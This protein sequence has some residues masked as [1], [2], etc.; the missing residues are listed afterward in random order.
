MG[1]GGQRQVQAFGS[2]QALRF[3]QAQLF[4]VL[5]RAEADDMAEVVV[6]TGE[7][8]AAQFHQLR[9]AGCCIFRCA[10]ARLMCSGWPF[11]W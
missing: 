7:A 1:D 2:D 10:M 6:E 4:L 8:H 5:Q 9:D 3:G 11:V